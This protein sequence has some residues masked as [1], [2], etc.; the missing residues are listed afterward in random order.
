MKT[1]KYAGRFLLRSKSYTVINLLGL[2]FSLACCIILI[3]YIHQEMT[4]DTHCI[5]PEQVYIP[6]RDIDGNVFPGNLAYADTTYFAPESVAE[7]SLFITFEDETIVVDDVPYSA[8]ILV[9]DSLFSH[10]FRYPVIEGTDVLRDPQDALIKQSFARRI[11]GNQNPIG[12]TLQ[13]GNNPPLTIRGVLDEAPCKSS[14]LFDVLV[15]KTLAKRWGRLDGELIRFMP[16]VDVD[17]INA[18]SNVYKVTESGTLRYRLVQLS[19]HYWDEELLTKEKAEKM[20]IHGSRSHIALLSGVCL[21][22]L[23][24]GVLNFVNIYMVSMMKRS[25]EYGLKKVFGISGRSLFAQLWMEN[26]LL[27]SCAIFL[28]WVIVEVT[29]AP[30]EALL[31]NEIPSGNFDWWLSAGIWLL[32]P[33]ITV[34]YPYLRYYYLP[35]VTSIRAVGTSRSSIFTRKVFLFVQYTI[36]FL[37]IILSIYF[38]RHLDVMLHTSPGFRTEG[39]LTAELLRESNPWQLSDEGRMKRNDHIMEIRTR[40][41]ECPLITTWSTTDTEILGNNS[42]ITLLNDKGGKVNMETMFISSDFF[43]LYDLKAKEGTL[44]DV[45]KGMATYLIVMNESALKAFG[46]TNI[47]EAFVRGEQPLWTM[48][49]QDGSIVEGGL[50]LMPV[51]AVIPDYYSGHITKGKKP[52]VYLV[53]SRY[54]GKYRIACT[55]GRENELMD[56]LRKLE[57]E[58]Y[59]TTDFEYIWMKDQVKALYEQDRQLATVY[60]LFAGIAIFISCLGLFGLSLFDIRQRYREIAIRKVNGAPRKALYLMLC[61]KYTWIVAAA[62]CLSAPISWYIIS[63]YTQGFVVKM[64]IGISIYILALTIVL[65]ISLGTLMWQIRK[66]TRV[67]PAIIMK[68]E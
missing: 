54:S 34:I 44:P 31:K 3:R 40:L 18:I 27:I 48:A 25:R 10:F 28:A 7:R 37:L 41:D 35:P 46:Y 55:P 64:P 13:F 65:L 59:H 50:E 51:K 29:S 58:I 57:K 20:R 17:A 15:N 12:K 32:L 52:I 53:G 24:S 22:L 33:L 67:N 11:F 9:T 47:N 5:N 14:F 4:V 21:L 42:T 1:L 56:Y 8:Q 63:L 43:G 45:A 36:T 49:Y 66:A 23:L 39:I 26:M 61:K 60:M 16:G 62:F 2:A 68:T 38:G 30:T 6:M 19:Q